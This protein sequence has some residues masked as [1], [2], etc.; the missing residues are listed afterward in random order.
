MR[1]DE[2]G[3]PQGKADFDYTDLIS[4]Q[5]QTQ[6]KKCGCGDFSLWLFIVTIYELNNEGG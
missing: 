2:A 6:S 1:E 3:G 4:K 5:K